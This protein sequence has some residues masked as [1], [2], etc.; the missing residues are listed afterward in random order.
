MYLNV[1]TGEPA[2]SWLASV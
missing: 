1:V 2:P